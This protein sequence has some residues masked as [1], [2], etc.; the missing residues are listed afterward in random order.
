MKYQAYIKAFVFLICLAP[1]GRL[2]YGAFTGE[3]LGANPIE[4]IIRDLGT[5]GL[6]FI[7]ISLAIT[8]LRKLTGWNWL[9]KFRRMMGLFGFFY[10]CCHFLSYIWWDQYFD[11]QAIWKDVLKRPFITVGFIAFLGLI[12]LAVTSTNSMVKRLGGKRWQTLHRLVY[13]I[14][15]LGVLH[16]WWLV[17]RDITKPAIYASILFVFL[18][19]RIAKSYSQRKQQRI[20]S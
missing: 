13:P 17:K 16:Y 7:L 3:I 2:G 1:I 12:P 18:S 8:P 10:I 5:W 15:I 11:W 4:F 6:T 20:I 14:A 19:F 9:I